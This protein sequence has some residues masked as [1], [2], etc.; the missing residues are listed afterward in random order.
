MK[1]TTARP[2]RR[3]THRNASSIVVEN[4]HSTTLAVYLPPQSAG[5]GTYRRHGRCALHDDLRNLLKNRDDWRN[6]DLNGG[7]GDA[8]FEELPPH[9]RAASAEASARR[10]RPSDG[11]SAHVAAPRVR[12]RRATSMMGRFR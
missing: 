1:P 6:A 9:P 10:L 7:G 12:T 5:A 8:F 4:D 3:V 2:W 11:L